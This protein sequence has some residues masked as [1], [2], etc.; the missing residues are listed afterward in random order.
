MSGEKTAREIAYLAL[1][2]M[3][4][5]KGYSNLVLDS[6]LKDASI[7]LKDRALVSAIFYGVLEKK[8][9]LDFFLE[10]FYRDPKTKPRLAVLTALRMGAYQILYLE[11]IP[12][13]AAVNETVSLLKGRGLGAYSGFANGVLRA[14]A[15]DV[16][17]CKLPAG[18][19]ALELSIRYSVDEQIVRIFLESYGKDLTLRLLDSFSERAKTYIKTNT[20]KISTADLEKRLAAN[21]AELE[22]LDFPAGAGVLKYSGS[23]MNLQEYGEGLFHVEDLSAQFIPEVLAPKPGECI[24]DFCAAPGGKTFTIAEKLRGD[25]R[26]ISVD[27]S[28]S[29]MK[30]LRSGAKRL[31][32]EN[33]EFVTADASKPVAKLP[34]ADGVLCDVP[35]SG[36]GVMRRK[37]E[38]RY[39]DIDEIGKLPA[40]QYAILESSAEKVL[41]GG[42]L[43]Y[44]TCTLNRSENG[45]VTQKFLREHPEFFPIAVDIPGVSRVMD[46]PENELSIF[47]FS[48]ASDGFFVAAFRKK[49]EFYG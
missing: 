25:G 46:E 15:R 31:G 28:D 27:L 41:P 34:M 1:M 14:L 19:S 35:C 11:K 42:R 17:S 24:I 48:G 20:L 6:A 8:I 23:P 26:L 49:S 43:V 7:S 29:R 22:P 36:L 39:K 4:R 9:S 2:R 21:S 38:I 10:K 40:L 37:P 47:P 32:I 18:D 45:E 12:N 13:S 3:E 16:E 44:S 33:I 5:D 30:L